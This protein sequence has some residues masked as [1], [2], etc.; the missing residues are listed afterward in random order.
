MSTSEKSKLE[1]VFFGSTCYASGKALFYPLNDQMNRAI[2]LIRER[3]IRWTQQR[4]RAVVGS[5]LSLKD[6][7]VSLFP[8]SFTTEG[9]FFA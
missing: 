3:C 4:G 8:I 7:T 2:S 6:P 1:E 5:C 9:R